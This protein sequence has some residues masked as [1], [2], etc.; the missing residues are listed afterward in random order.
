MPRGRRRSSRRS[1]GVTYTVDEQIAWSLARCCRPGDVLVVGVATP[2]AAAAGQ[3]ARELLVPDLV[4]IEA[5]A[6]DVAPHDVATPMVRPGGD[7]RRGGRRLH[8]GRD[9]RRDPA[10]PRLAPVRQPGPGRRP[11]QPSTRAACAPPDG[12]MR[13]LPGGLAHADIACLIGQAR[14]LPGRQRTSASSPSRWTSSPARRGASPRSS[15]R[16]PSSTGTASA[17]GSLPARRASRVRRPSPAAASRS[18]RPTR[19]P[20]TEPAASGGDAGCC[21]RRSTRTRCGGSRPA[22]AGPRRCASSRR[23]RDGG[24]EGSAVYEGERTLGAVLAARADAAAGP[25]DRPL[26]GDGA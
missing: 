25:R 14:R 4:L 12:S 13:R 24:S 3:L 19:V 11:R 17:S 8:P 26:R 20:V 15:P 16:R 23:C 18:T 5:A 10:R 22:R 7:R 9:P 2:L 21:A 6:V 1:D